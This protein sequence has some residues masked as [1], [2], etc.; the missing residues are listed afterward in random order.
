MVFSI[1]GKG[2]P[3]GSVPE[4]AGA[5]SPVRTNSRRQSL[6]ICALAVGYP[7]ALG[8]AYE[9]AEAEISLPNKGLAASIEVNS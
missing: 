4:I 9:R 2:P 5:N 7:Y 6:C 3:C 8:N 1:N